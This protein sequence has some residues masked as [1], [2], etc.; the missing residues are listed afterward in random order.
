M[1]TMKP[2][3][4]PGPDNLQPEF[5]CAPAQSVLH[6]LTTLLSKCLCRKKIP[7]I[8]KFLKIVAIL[9][10]NEPANKPKIYR[11][12]KRLLCVPFKLFERSSTTGSNT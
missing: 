6:M 5:F 7:K 3:K 1:Q 2:G 9:K 10:P 8:W 4:D 11:L 12:K